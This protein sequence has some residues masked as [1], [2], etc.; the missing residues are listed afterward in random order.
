M[1]EPCYKPR[2]GEAC[3]TRLQIRIS[4]NTSG[5]EVMDQLTQMKCVA[6]RKGEP[7]LTDAE[8]AEFRPQLPAWNIIEVDGIKRLER[9]L[10]FDTF[11]HALAFTNKVAE[12]TEDKG[13]P[14]PHLAEWV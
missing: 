14:T 13:T 12:M 7:T 5:V 8:I 10:N 2:R 9:G 4:C 1:C 11:V 3:L 6:C